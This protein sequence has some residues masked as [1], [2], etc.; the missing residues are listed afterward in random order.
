[1]RTLAVV[2]LSMAA[3]SA[4]ENW[5]DQGIIHIDKS[6]YAKLHSVP[7]RAVTMSEGFWAPRRRVVSEVSIPSSL[8]LIEQSGVMDNF[9]RLTGQKGRAVSRAG[10]R[11]FRHL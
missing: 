3:L 4:A 5:R 11:G 10:V 9:R 2:L 8:R 1:M 7:V 6:P